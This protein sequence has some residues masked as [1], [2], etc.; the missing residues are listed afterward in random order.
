MTDFE[1]YKQLLIETNVY[2]ISDIDQISISSLFNAKPSIQ[3]DYK[4]IG[5]SRRKILLTFDDDGKLICFDL[6]D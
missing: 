5:K 6:G 4:N 3:N 1:K 2:F